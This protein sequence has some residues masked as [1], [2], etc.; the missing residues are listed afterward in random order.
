MAVHRSDVTRTT[1][2]DVRQVFRSSVG[3]QSL[4][5]RSRLAGHTGRVFAGLSVRPH[6][7]IATLT[8]SAL[9]YIKVCDWN[10]LVSSS[11]AGWNFFGVIPLIVYIVGDV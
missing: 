4:K 2:G 5:R 11:C 1:A 6:Q 8:A 3:H 10:I 9:F 7:V